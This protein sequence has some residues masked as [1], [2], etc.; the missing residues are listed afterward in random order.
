MKYDQDYFPGK[1]KRG[2]DYKEGIYELP[3]YYPRQNTTAFKEVA[4]ILHP[5]LEEYAFGFIT[6]S[7]V[8][9]RENGD[10]EL[11]S[12]YVST[13]HLYIGD[14]FL[15][16]SEEIIRPNLSIR[17]GIAGEVSTSAASP[18][19]ILYAANARLN[20]ASSNLVC[21]AAIDTTA[22]GSKRRSP[23]YIFTLT[24]IVKWECSSYGRALA[25]H[26]RGTG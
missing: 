14:V 17:E 15:V 18:K 12:V 20:A 21:Y 19:C 5:H 13:N 4:I 22:I 25:L 10:E 23:G 3:F 2:K 7:L 11:C 6:S 24:A 26:A 16:N 8:L 1:R 9:R